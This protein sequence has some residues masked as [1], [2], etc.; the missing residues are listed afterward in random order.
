MAQRRDPAGRELS[1]GLLLDITSLKQAN[2]QAHSEAARASA[3]SP[4][5]R[6]TAGSVTPA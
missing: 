5:P 1:Q 2:E 4:R 3:L 6:S